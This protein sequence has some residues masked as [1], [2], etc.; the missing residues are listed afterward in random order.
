M[1][2]Q[3]ASPVIKGTNIMLH[4]ST[5]AV[6]PTQVVTLTKLGNNYKPAKNTAQGNAAT[7]AT[8]QA[9]LAKKQTVATLT[10]LVT[11]KHNHAPFVGYALRRG[12]LQAK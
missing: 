5:K 8:I 11:T 10:K 3:G 9:A 4:Q 2:W 6:K 7:W 12:W 1:G